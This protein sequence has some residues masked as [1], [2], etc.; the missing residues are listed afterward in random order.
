M[1]LPDLLYSIR[2][3]SAQHLTTVGGHLLVV[4][5]FRATHINEGGIMVAVVLKNAI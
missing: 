3:A 1:S 4:H 5:W 2:E